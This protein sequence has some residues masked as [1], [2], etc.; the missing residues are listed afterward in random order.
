MPTAT[1]EGTH[2]LPSPAGPLSVQTHHSPQS[3][4]QPQIITRAMC[5]VDWLECFW[6]PTQA[7]PTAHTPPPPPF[8]DFA[9]AL[10]PPSSVSSPQLLQHVTRLAALS[11]LAAWGASR[12]LSRDSRA[13]DVPLSLVYETLLVL[14]RRASHNRTARGD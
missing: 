7:Q 12:Q 3:Q 1:E 10:A 5:W 13:G 8:P 11:F 6:A 4:P 9:H 2:P 14:G